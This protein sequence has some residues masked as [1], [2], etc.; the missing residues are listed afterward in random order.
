MRVYTSAI[1]RFS[2]R[3]RCAGQVALWHAVACAAALGVLPAVASTAR[4]EEPQQAPKTL[5]VW[6]HARPLDFFGDH[7]DAS[8][9]RAFEMLPAR[10]A[11]LRTEIP[12]LED[13]PPQVIDALVG[14]LSL[15]VRIAVID[16]GP[17]PETGAPGFGAVIQFAARDEQHAARL[18]ETMK[19]LAEMAPVQPELRDS[20]RFPGMMEI[21]APMGVVALGP[22]R[23]ENGAWR[24]ELRL[25]HLGETAPLFAALPAPPQGASP[26]ARGLIDLGAFAPLT[27]M[28]GM[29][30][31][32]QEPAAG[33][34]FKSLEAEGFIGPDAMTLEFSLGHGDGWLIGRGVAKDAVTK[35][36]SL[37]S[38]QSPLADSDLRAI[39]ADATAAL[40]GRHDWSKTWE[41]LVSLIEVSPEGAEMLAMFTERTGVDLGRDVVGA[42]GTVTGAYTS[43]SSGGG[44]MLSAVGLVSVKDRS[45]LVTACDRLCATANQAIDDV[46]DGPGDYVRLRRWTMGGIDYIGLR[47]D[48]LPI[49]IELTGAITDRWLIAGFTPQAVAAAIDQAAGRGDAGISANPAFTRA[50][51]IPLDRVSA[52]EFIDSPRQLRAGYGLT[53]LLM[54]AI[55]N[56]VRIPGSGGE[57]P[58]S[59]LPPFRALAADAKPMLQVAT[60]EGDDLVIHWRLDRSALV[61]MTGAVGAYSPGA[62]L[63]WPA[64]SAGILLP[65]LGRARSNAQVLKDSTQLRQIHTAMVMYATEHRDR[66]PDS[67]DELVEGGF[68]DPVL[69]ESPIGAV[70]DGQGDYFLRLPGR[71]TFDSEHVTGYSRA[72]YAA[73][74]LVNVLYDDGFVAP[75]TIEE[76]HELIKTPKNR[77]VDWRLPG[78]AGER[79]QPDFMIRP[80]A[81]KSR[82]L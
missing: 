74:R 76:F 48:G 61:N 29:M 64:L 82:A 46:E 80:P 77:D 2:S 43:E 71:S 20:E 40:L 44:G 1:A 49:P 79:R 42:L 23:A 9:R 24:Y 50:L 37:A 62:F 41:W 35:S 28:L 8:L 63:A 70:D 58:A 5:L 10:L 65:A 47:F 4:A 39:P 6:E 30:A 54:S 7:K 45:R 3:T 57:S 25:A 15:P 12:D 59:I 38:M 53:S 36:A 56:G 31:A 60:I 34:I 33:A 75:M 78:R 14:F 26:L 67:V 16:R 69:L 22:Q 17:D 81:G 21:D 72:G 11:H 51:P 55:N 66:Y 73:A 68:L 19:S 52:L 32:A 13:A 18:H 27:G